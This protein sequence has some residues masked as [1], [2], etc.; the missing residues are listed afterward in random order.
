[1]PQVDD[2]NFFGLHVCDEILSPYQVV[3]TPTSTSLSPRP[4]HW[5]IDSG[6]TAA[7][8]KVE[9][10]FTT[11]EGS[12][13][14]LSNPPSLSVY[15]GYASG[16]SKA[17][18]V[19]E[20]NVGDLEKHD[21]TMV[22]TI[23]V[24]R[25]W[26]AHAIL[27]MIFSG[28]LSALVATQLLSSRWTAVRP[29]P[30]GPWLLCIFQFMGNPAAS[31]AT[32]KPHP[33]PPSRLAPYHDS[34]RTTVMLLPSPSPLPPVTQALWLTSLALSLG[35]AVVASLLKQKA[36][37]AL[38]RVSMTPQWLCPRVRSDKGEYA[39]SGEAGRPLVDM[40]K[41]FYAI[42]AGHL[43]SVVLY[44]WGLSV[45]LLR[46]SNPHQVF[47]LVVVGSGAAFFLGQFLIVSAFSRVTVHHPRRGLLVEF[48]QRTIL[49]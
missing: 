44:L 30:P 21:W 33:Q 31:G 26:R 49:L 25:S 40:T 36:C 10:K 11:D 45:P 4:T 41:F 20:V 35:C 2:P 9:F 19:D 46:D 1:M 18:A 24:I 34:G 13:P 27:L 42:H 8:D 29:L 17:E 47:F 5:H 23:A 12:E 28:L 37:R 16:H 32:S 38:R 48:S 22:T 15:N 3:E 14:R 6:A 39:Y 43:L 7:D